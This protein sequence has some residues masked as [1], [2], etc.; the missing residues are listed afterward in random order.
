V[1]ISHI[2]KC[3]GGVVSPLLANIYLHYVLDQWV[4]WWRRKYARGDVIIVRFADDF[5]AGFE[6]LGDA[7]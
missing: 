4:R 3:V 6:H 2:A 7:K 1:T 5:T